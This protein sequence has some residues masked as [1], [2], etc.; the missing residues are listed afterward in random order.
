MSRGVWEFWDD[1]STATAAFRAGVGLGDVGVN[2]EEGV[3]VQGATIVGTSDDDIISVFHT[4][5]GQ[6]FATFGDDVIEGKGGNDA[7]YGDDGDDT[8]AGGPAGAG[9]LN[10][11]W[12]GVG[13]DTASYAGT[14]SP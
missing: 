4:V 3:S 6:P 14:A 10:Q 1:V 9:G 2:I 11:L 5:D 8:L 13:S 12:G 7:L